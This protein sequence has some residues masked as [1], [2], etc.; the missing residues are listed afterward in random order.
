[1]TQGRV[2]GADVYA[3]DGRLRR[4]ID[5]SSTVAS[6]EPP[7]GWEARASALLPRL[8]LYPQP[9]SP[10]LAAAIERRLNLPKGS[11]LVGSG[12]SE[13]LEWMAQAAR[14]RRVWLESP[15]FGEYLPLLRR[16]AA[17]PQPLPLRRG[18]GRPA[19]A[20]L[21]KGLG[22]GWLWLA[23]PANPSGLS[24]AW[25]DLA[26]LI[27]QGRRRGLGVVVDEALAA[28]QLSP[29]PDL[30]GLAAA[31]PGLVLLRSLGKGL[32]LPGLRLGYLVA[33]P[34]VVR[35][36]RPWTRPWSV[37]SLAQALGPWMLEAELLAMPSLR[38][39]LA[40]RRADLLARLSPLAP[41]G[42]ALLPSDSGAFL[43][44]LP[45][46]RSA[47]RTAERLE[48]EGLLVRSC[49]TYGSWGRRHLRL[50]PQRPKENR[51]LAA[52]LARIL[53]ERS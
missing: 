50:N 48:K 22:P 4:L 49:H 14:G 9:H 23:D 29:R 36:L 39:A 7:D 30:S 46:G 19:L 24:L 37:N 20:P 27:S 12:S 35:S 34:K 25:D 32:G 17:I 33:H 40:G 38:R 31:R 28:Q 43:V 3:D 45:P 47:A 13:C 1:M 44:A 5:F 2:H 51:L 15:C 42:L 26:A 6:L 8:G 18:P 11:V 52:A 16:A 41:Q 53:K 21:A 10:G